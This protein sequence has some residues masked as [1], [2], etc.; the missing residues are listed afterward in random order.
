MLMKSL[1]YASMEKYADAKRWADR[2]NALHPNDSNIGGYKG[3]LNKAH[4][5]K[6][7]RTATN[8]S[9]GILRVLWAMVAGIFKSSVRWPPSSLPARRPPR[10]CA[11]KLRCSLSR[12]FRPLMMIK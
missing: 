8:V 5:Q 10:A 7:M 11:G 1:A 4:S 3:E 12:Y 9:G 6:T 2:A